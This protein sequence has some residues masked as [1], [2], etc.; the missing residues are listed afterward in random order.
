MLKLNQQTIGNW[1]DRGELPCVRVGRRVRIKR[2]DLDQLIQAGY[3]GR[4]SRPSTPP[5][6]RP[7]G[8]AGHATH[9]CDVA[10]S[11]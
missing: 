4:Q 9:T 5:S 10:E 1:L 6:P 11:C 3:T 2:S 8:W 7:G